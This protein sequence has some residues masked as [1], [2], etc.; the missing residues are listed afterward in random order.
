MA[1]LIFSRKFGDK[2]ILNIDL[3]SLHQEHI[4]HIILLLFHSPS[5]NLFTNCHMLVH[6]KTLQQHESKCPFLSVAPNH[7]LVTIIL[8]YYLKILR[9]VSQ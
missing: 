7:L 3:Y 8:A 2:N 6:L 4:F 5:L 9:K 1:M